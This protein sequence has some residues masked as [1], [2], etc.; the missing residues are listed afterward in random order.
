MFPVWNTPPMPPASIVVKDSEGTIGDKVAY[1]KFNVLMAAGAKNPL[2]NLLC[3]EYEVYYLLGGEWRL[4][5][6]GAAQVRSDPLHS[7]DNSWI[8]FECIWANEMGQRPDKVRATIWVWDSL[9]PSLKSTKTTQEFE[10]V[11]P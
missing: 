6:T 7:H 8:M 11:D 5:R 2:Y 9:F 10:V 3:Y 4:Y 1:G